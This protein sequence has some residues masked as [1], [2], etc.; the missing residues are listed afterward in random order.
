MTSRP[1]SKITQEPR[2]RRKWIFLSLIL[3]LGC[4]GYFFIRKSL[5]EQNTDEL[6]IRKMVTSEELILEL[7]PK[8]DELGKGLMNL[9]LPDPELADS[10]FEKKLSSIGLEAIPENDESPE[11]KTLAREIQ[12]NRSKEALVSSSEFSPW[13]AILEGV[14]FFESGIFRIVKGEFIGDEFE[15][16]STEVKFGGL[17]RRLDDKWMGLSGKQM[18][19][20]RKDSEGAWRISA[21]KSKKMTANI[22]GQL[23]FSESLDSAIPNR[24]ELMQ[25]RRS[26][27]QEAAVVYYQS[28]KTKMLSF[29]FSPTAM[30]QK[31]AISVADVDGDGHDD[32]YIMVRLGTNLLL[33][34]QGDGTFREAA[35]DFE[36]AVPGNT[37]C[38]IFA[39]FDNDGDQDLMLGRALER[40]VYYENNEG[41]FREVKQEIPLPNLAV[42]MAAAD[43]NNDGLLDLF[44]ATHRP[45]SVGTGLGIESGNSGKSWPER[46]LSPK[47]AAKFREKFEY[48]RSGAIPHKGFLNQTGPPNILL[49][50]KG[51]GKLEPAPETSQLEGWE[52][53]LQASWSDFDRDGDP[54]L[55]VANDWAPDHLYRNDGEDG[56]TDIAKE[57]G[58]D[59]F[60]FA[61]GA[62]WG[63]YNNDGHQDLYVSNMYSKAG[64]RIMSQVRG[65]DSDLLISAEG[66]YLYRQ[67]EHGKFSH[68]SGLEKPSL[69]VADAGW[70][71][72]G[73]F[74]DFDNDGDLDIYAL[75]GYFTAPAAVA[76]QVD[77]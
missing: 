5:D 27:H 77:L 47:V 52:N 38:S 31:P 13:Q 68:V 33:H 10:L 72:G 32:I 66:N 30:N 59:V 43:Y 24:Q 11:Q 2:H 48:S 7:T 54:D 70:S 57:V 76:S 69:L 29:D 16:F 4:G 53:T 51:G 44:V 21:W 62:S 73:Q 46:F 64:R 25:I 23:L 60:G 50:N 15:H 1:P 20:W 12:L 63:D 6:L 39:D 28:R 49:V 8:L 45:G 56:F 67:N 22:V 71:W 40:S 36:I 65:L 35:A 3:A 41:W 26:I 55:Y 17:A 42:S 58:A 61:M 74:V 14:S 37:T 18:V 19:E 75:S 34:N 9:R